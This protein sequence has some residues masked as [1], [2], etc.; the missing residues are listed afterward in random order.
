MI[1]DKLKLKVIWKTEECLEKLKGTA[2][3][4]ELNSLKRKYIYKDISGSEF[5]DDLIYLKNIV[6]LFKNPITKWDLI[7]GRLKNF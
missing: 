1:N 3:E 4:R 5:V 6:D 7:N 2:Y